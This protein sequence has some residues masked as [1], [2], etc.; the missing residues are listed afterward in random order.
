MSLCCD[1]TAG[2]WNPAACSHHEVDPF[3]DQPPV[4]F[5]ISPDTD[6]SHESRPSTLTQKTGSKNERLWYA[7][8]ACNHQ[9][10][11]QRRNPAMA[12]RPIWL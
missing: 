9:W 3:D 8:Q 10:R 1:V 5:L 2:A 6:S 4:D 12:T 11:I 7:I